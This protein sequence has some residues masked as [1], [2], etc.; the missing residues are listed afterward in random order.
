MLFRLFATTYQSRFKFNNA[1]KQ[2]Q[3]Q[4]K[5]YKI[6]VGVEEERRRRRKECGREE[7]GGRKWMEAV[8]RNTDDGEKGRVEGW[9]AA[10]GGERGRR[11]R[12]W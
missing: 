8:G 9:R 2:V 4:A 11:G 1:A 12:R 10:R 3:E 7:V 5:G 6:A